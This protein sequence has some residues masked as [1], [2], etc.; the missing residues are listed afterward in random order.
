MGKLFEKC[1]ANVAPE[2]MEEVNLN[3]EIVNKKSI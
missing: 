3:A 1:F 2:V